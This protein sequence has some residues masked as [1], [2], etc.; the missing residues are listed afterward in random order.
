V[1]AR[2]LGEYAVPLWRRGGFLYRGDAFAAFG[3]FGL[4][5]IDDL[6]LR[7]TSVRQALPIDLTAD[8]GLRMDTYIGIF[9][10]SVAN[11]LG[12]LPL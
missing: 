11:G 9:T 1:A 12:R 3:V 2:T 7:D 10:L 8:L 4:G 6:R 5:S